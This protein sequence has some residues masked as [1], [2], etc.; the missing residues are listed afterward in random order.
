MAMRATHTVVCEIEV[1]ASSP[2]MAARIARDL[3]MDPTASIQ[4]DV[5]PMEYVKDADDWMPDDDHGWSIW[6]G[7]RLKQAT[8]PMQPTECV[9]WV[10]AK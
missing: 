8:N 5:L 3:M 10:K 6:F 4:M 2:E 1:C 7:H 9:E